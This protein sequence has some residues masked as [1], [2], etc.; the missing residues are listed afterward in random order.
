[1]VMLAGFRGSGD[2]NPTSLYFWL[3]DPQT[4]CTIQ[5]LRLPDSI[6]GGFLGSASTVVEGH[7]A[8]TKRAIF[9]TGPGLG[10]YLVEWGNVLVKSQL[11]WRLPT[12]RPRTD[13]LPIPLGLLASSCGRFLAATT[14]REIWLYEVCPKS[15]GGILLRYKARASCGT[16][17]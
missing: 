17:R 14:E 6:F 8:L 15:I 4:G 13:A 1:M 3:L 16:K 12:P 2:E 11:L 5:M 7:I 10:I 9:F